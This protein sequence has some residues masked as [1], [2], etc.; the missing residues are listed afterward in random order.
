M[1]LRSHLLQSTFGWAFLQ[2]LQ[3][4]FLILSLSFSFGTRK[5]ITASLNI[6]S[7]SFLSIYGALSAGVHPQVIVSLFVMSPPERR[8]MA[9]S[10]GS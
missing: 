10:T 8:R 6:S 3:Y 4:S 9:L 1:L 2:D 7:L 5:A